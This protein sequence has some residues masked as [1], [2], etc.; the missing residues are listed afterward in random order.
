[1][2]K[3]KFVSRYPGAKVGSVAMINGIKIDQK[4]VGGFKVRVVSISGKP[5]PP[6]WIA[7][8]YFFEPP[9][10]GSWKDLYKT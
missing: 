9:D 4:F 8:S 2:I 3:V 10:D 1:M 6:R 5:V 7:I